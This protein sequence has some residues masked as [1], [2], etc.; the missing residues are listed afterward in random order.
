VYTILRRRGDAA[1]VPEDEFF[2]ALASDPELARSVRGEIEQLVEV[3]LAATGSLPTTTVTPTAAVTTSS[4][5]SSSAPPTKSSTTLPLQ[6]SFAVSPSLAKTARKQQ[7]QRKKAEV[8]HARSA[9]AAGSISV[10]AVTLMQPGVKHVL[11]VMA[12]NHWMVHQLMESLLNL[13]IPYAQALST[14]ADAA[15]VWSRAFLYART[16]VANIGRVCGANHWSLAR[17]HDRLAAML[18]MAGQPAAALPEWS[19]AYDIHRRLF[20]EQADSTRRAKA[21]VDEPPQTIEQL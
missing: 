8:V 21:R 1:T 18:V 10:A 3:V 2:D 20:G 7:R 14:T 6:S 12:P 16:R 11:E 4:S 17:E 9:A 19:A 5:S 15:P 13:T